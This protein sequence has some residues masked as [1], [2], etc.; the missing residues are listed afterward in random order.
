VLCRPHKNP[1]GHMDQG[2][3]RSKQFPANGWPSDTVVVVCSNEATSNACAPRQRLDAPEL[4][5]PGLPEP[6]WCCGRFS[7]ALRLGGLADRMTGLA[8]PELGQEAAGELQFGRSARRHHPPA[9]EVG[10][11]Y[12][13]RPNCANAFRLITGQRRYLRRTGA[14]HAGNLQHRRRHANFGKLPGSAVAWR[15]RY[16]RTGNAGPERRPLRRRR[17][18]GKSPSGR[19]DIHPRATLE[20]GWRK[21]RLLTRGRS[22]APK[23]GSTATLTS[24]EKSKRTIGHP[25]SLRAPRKK[26]ADF[27]GPRWADV[28]FDCLIRHNSTVFRGVWRNDGLAF[29]DS[30]P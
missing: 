17:R 7:K 15:G 9:A 10:R 13:R 24:T 19:K 4:V 23:T 30:G 29:G 20:A 21:N 1:L 12:P 22:A 25:T 28:G 6:S 3:G 14:E 5:R 11:V 16:I 27:V 8:A 26:R 2:R 18:L